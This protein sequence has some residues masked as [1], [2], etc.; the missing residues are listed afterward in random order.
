MAECDPS[1]FRKSARLW[2]TDAYFKYPGWLAEGAGHVSDW[3]AGMLWHL[4]PVLASEN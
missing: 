2:D 3:Q 4:E 1:A